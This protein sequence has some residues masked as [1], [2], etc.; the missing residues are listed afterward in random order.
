LRGELSILFEQSL[1]MG[2]RDV[3][4]PNPL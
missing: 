3:D 2:E 4:R 1:R